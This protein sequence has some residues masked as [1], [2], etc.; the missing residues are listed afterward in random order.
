MPGAF[1]LF[2]FIITRVKNIEKT[3]NNNAQ[4]FVFHNKQS[5]ESLDEW[6]TSRSR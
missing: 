4:P 1:A 3:K 6:Q 2:Y 5:W